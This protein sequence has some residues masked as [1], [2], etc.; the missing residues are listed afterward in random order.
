M[1]RIKLNSVTAIKIFSV[2]IAIFLWFYAM[3]DINPT[4][5]REFSNI[6]VNTTELEEGYVMTSGQIPSISVKVSGK[7]SEIKSLS[8][9]DIS[10]DLDLNDYREGEHTIPVALRDNSK[11]SGFQVTSYPR[12]I[13]IKI[14]KII[15]KSFNIELQ[16]SG[17]TPDGIDIS[18]MELSEPAVSVKGTR[19][20]VE[21]VK[22]VV[23]KLD[24]S[25]IRDKEEIDLELIP[26]D[27]EGS[28]VKDVELSADSVKV[29][30]SYAQAVEAKVNLVLKG[31]L[32][33]GLKIKS[34]ALNPDKV[35]LKRI[36]ED[37]LAVDQVSTSEL[38]I[39]DID[40]DSQKKVGLVVPEGYEIS[41]EGSIMVDILVE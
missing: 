6:N 26:V 22:S 33:D 5:T 16:T 28:R 12:E 3:E 23:A 36:A 15:E 24:L 21:S 20:K 34:I 41:G 1:S 25:S 9:D 31:S 38:D 27:G 14:E 32:K 7:R 30:V 11:L 8:R 37:A 35:L 13:D 39:S 18:K 40:S 19:S 29:I 17:K 2:I 10:V 4:I